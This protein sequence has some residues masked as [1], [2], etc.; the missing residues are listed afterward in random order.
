MKIPGV[1]LL[2]FIFIFFSSCDTKKEDKAEPVTFDTVYDSKY[3]LLK[4]LG[5]TFHKRISIEGYLGIKSKT[6]LRA[7]SINL[8][9]FEQTKSRGRFITTN[10]P[11]GYNRN[12]AEK[13]PENYTKDDL[14]LHTNK[15]EIIG[16][17]V[18]VRITGK[19]Y[20][21][22]S[23]DSCYILVDTIEKAQ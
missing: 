11:F 17:D 10:I 3:N 4:I 13:L 1:I 12:Q 9:L 16:A 6:S 18:R 21:H 2:L 8:F 19:K 22:K 7:D 5:W 15:N 14:K 23:N 20:C